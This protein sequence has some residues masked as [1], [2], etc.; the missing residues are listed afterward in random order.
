M[1][2]G[3]ITALVT[4][5]KKGNLDLNALKRLIEFQ[6][7]KGI[8]GIVPCGTTGEAPTLSYDE[9]KKVIELTV[10]HV[11]KRVPVIAGTGANSTDEAIELT[12]FAKK[13][14]ADGALL[15]CPYYNK[16]T[17]EGLYRHFKK[18]AE[19]IDI[20]IILYNIPG[21]TGVNMLPETVARLAKIPNI[22]GI[23]EASGSLEQVTE[24]IRSTNEDFVVLSGDDAMTL[25]MLALGGKGVISVASN[26]IPDKIAK[27]VS[28]YLNKKVEEAKKIHYEY[29]DLMKALFIETNP[30]PVKT[31]M[32]MMKMICPEVRLPL[33]EMSEVNLSKLKGVLQ[34]YKLVK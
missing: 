2:K 19:T 34:K 27:M 4:P 23:K 11:K 26:I 10:K 9:H 13:A 15:V 24:I 28:L 30:V 5:F 20:P 29:Y 32:G 6:I 16:P 1:F 7:E 33:C 18:I 12:E 14:G 25:P 21:R 17:Q 3:A 8:D 31:A 22:V